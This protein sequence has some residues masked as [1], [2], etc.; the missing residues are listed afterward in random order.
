MEN[1]KKKKRRDR[2]KE[3]KLMLVIL[4]LRGL[5]TKN[6]SRQVKQSIPHT[7]AAF[8]SDCVKKCTDFIPNF[9]DKRTGC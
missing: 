4:T 2:G 5:F 6:S 9:G 8:Y 1:P 7:T 3:V